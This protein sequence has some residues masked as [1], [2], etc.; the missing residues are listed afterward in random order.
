[1]VHNK[2]PT[3][4]MHPLDRKSTRLNSSH[5]VISYAVF[6]LKKMKNRQS[7]RIGIAVPRLH[8][9]LERREN[10]SV[11]QDLRPTARADAHRAIRRR[12]TNRPANRLQGAHQVERIDAHD[13]ERRFERSKPP[14]P[15][16]PDRIPAGDED[17]A[18]VWQKPQRRE[19]VRLV[20][21]PP[22]DQGPVGPSF[23]RPGSPSPEPASPTVPEPPFGRIGGRTR[24]PPSC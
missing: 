24:P 22:R 6:C 17:E 13:P 18:V 2:P 12:R 1:M 4:A 23:N 5:L 19:H 8:A 9:F 10:R 14:E 11:R 3:E 16:G 7:H 21:P 15:S 20:E